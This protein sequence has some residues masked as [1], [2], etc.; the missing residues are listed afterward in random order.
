MFG[1]VTTLTKLIVV[2]EK[3]SCAERLCPGNVRVCQAQTI[4][5]GGRPPSGGHGNVVC[6][7]LQFVN[8]TTLD[9]PV[10]SARPLY[11]TVNTSK[12]H[13]RW[14]VRGTTDVAQ[15]NII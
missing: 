10:I 7:P 1:F 8:C 4:S 12:L 14:N 13:S 5:H 2:P 3:R 15:S 6:A 9:I 11:A